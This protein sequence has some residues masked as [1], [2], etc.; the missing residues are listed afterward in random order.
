MDIST[1]DHL[2]SI[3]SGLCAIAG[4]LL[5]LTDRRRRRRDESGP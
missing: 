1:L 3:A 4:T 5:I 2:A